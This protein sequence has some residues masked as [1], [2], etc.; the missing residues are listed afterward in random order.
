MYESVSSFMLFL[1]IPIVAMLNS[2]MNGIFVNPS[3]ETPDLMIFIFNLVREY[4][5]V[6]R[7]GTL[8]LSFAAFC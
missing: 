2:I 3:V 7:N 5:L 4:I 1:P 6:D 8:L